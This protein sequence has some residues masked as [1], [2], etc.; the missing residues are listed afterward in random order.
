MSWKKPHISKVYEAL[1]AI[2]DKRVELVSQTHSRCYSSSRNKYYEVEYDPGF[3]AIT[4][5]DNSAY[6]T[7]T[8]SYPMIAHLM[9]VGVIVYDTWLLQY[10]S[11]IHW[12]DINQKFKNNYEASI[13]FVLKELSNKGVDVS[14]LKAKVELLYQEVCTLELRHLGEKRQPPSAY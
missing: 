13:G 12:K 3:D 1:S 2:A 10:L 11:G 7:D 8:L 14:I 5:N 6:F 9:L 4:S